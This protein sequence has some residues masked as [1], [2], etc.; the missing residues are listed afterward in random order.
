MAEGLCD[1][2]AGSEWG[3]LGDGMGKASESWEGGDVIT[4]HGDGV[5]DEH[6]VLS[7]GSAH[8]KKHE[9]GLVS[10]GSRNEWGWGDP[11]EWYPTSAI[12]IELCTCTLRSYTPEKMG[13]I[14]F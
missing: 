1:G 12:P 9:A 6:G 5:R 2:G 8:T 11:T 10:E 14:L 3:R 7:P 13:S 4:E